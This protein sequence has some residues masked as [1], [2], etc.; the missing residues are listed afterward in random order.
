[1]KEISNL[2]KREFKNKH[3]VQHLLNLGSKV[4]HGGK[5]PQFRINKKVDIYPKSNRVF[6]LVKSEWVLATDETILSVVLG[7]LAEEKEPKKTKKLINLN[8]TQWLALQKQ[9]Q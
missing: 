9:H 5:S 3:L 1:M 7:I 4:E 8:F 6:N 2:P